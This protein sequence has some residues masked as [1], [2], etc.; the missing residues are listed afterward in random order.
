MACV[1]LRILRWDPGLPSREPAG[2]G[3]S[4]VCLSLGPVRCATAWLSPAT[5]RPC[6]G[7][8]PQTEQLWGRPRSLPG[9]APRSDLEHMCTHAFRC[10]C[11]CARVCSESSF[12]RWWVSYQEPHSGWVSCLVSDAPEQLLSLMSTRRPAEQTQ[13]QQWVSLGRA[14]AW[15]DSAQT[16][17]LQSSLS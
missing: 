1:M 16:P 5:F 10:V 15:H 8:E 7:K 13:G 17:S 9:P 14:W 4:P 2:L 12:P 6:L 3:S 11:V